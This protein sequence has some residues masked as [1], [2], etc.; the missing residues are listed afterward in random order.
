MVLTLDP[1]SITGNTVI[2]LQLLDTKSKSIIIN[3]KYKVARVSSNLEYQYDGFFCR[4]HKLDN[5][6]GIA[7][8]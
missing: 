2:E 3:T 6:I 5:I 7:G 8:Y 4:N 1:A